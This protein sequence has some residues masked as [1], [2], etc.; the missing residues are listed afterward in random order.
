MQLD[1]DDQK[2]QQDAWLFDIDHGYQPNLTH[3]AFRLGRAPR[4]LP[5]KEKV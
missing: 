2:S 4:P 5:Q 1:V 3:E